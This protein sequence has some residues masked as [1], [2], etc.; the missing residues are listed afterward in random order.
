MN[1]DYLV[2]QSTLSDIANSIREK[3]GSTE[4]M[5]VNEMPEAIA[6]ISSGGGNSGG[7]E[8]CT[9]RIE[10]PEPR[11]IPVTLYYLDKNSN[12]QTL[13][14]SLPS[15]EEVS[16]EVLKNSIVCSPNLNL[17]I[18]DQYSDEMLIWS[19]DNPNSNI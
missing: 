10:N 11:A 18:D 1:N 4:P 9:M 2:K 19:Y 13:N 14:I 6:S 17:R 8:T 16:I 7:A 5:S 15:F 12:F 3:T